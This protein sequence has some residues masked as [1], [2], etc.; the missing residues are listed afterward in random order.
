M[1]TLTTDVS[2]KQNIAPN[3]SKN[4]FYTFASWNMGTLL[5]FNSISIYTFIPF[6]FTTSSGSVALQSVYRGKLGANYVYAVG[7][8]PGGGAVDIA[9]VGEQE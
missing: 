8:P 4:Y 2:V 6:V 9:I 5:S 1:A 3:S 7:S